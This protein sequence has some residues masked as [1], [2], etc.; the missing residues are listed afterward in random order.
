MAAASGGQPSSQNGTCQVTAKLQCGVS[1]I[2]GQVRDTVH[3]SYRV[4]RHTVSPRLLT[5]TVRRSRL[6][7]R[8]LALTGRRQAG[9]SRSLAEVMCRL[10]S[11]WTSDVGDAVIV[12]D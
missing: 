3:R 5:L 11:D 9:T 6:Q 7:V 2:P 1:C 10:Q 4:A 12:E 8:L